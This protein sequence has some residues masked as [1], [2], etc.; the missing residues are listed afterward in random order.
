MCQTLDTVTKKN[1]KNKSSHPWKLHTRAWPPSSI[2]WLTAANRAVTADGP[3]PSCIVSM[4]GAD[5]SGTFARVCS[6]YA[7]VVHRDLQVCLRCV[8]MPYW[9]W[10]QQ[11]VCFFFF[12]SNARRGYKRRPSASWL[13]EMWSLCQNGFFLLWNIRSFSSTLT[14]VALESAQL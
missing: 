4:C 6:V 3:Q 11:L 1:P 5:E 14:A 2:F 13:W 10:H 9:A 7:D 8:F 12:K